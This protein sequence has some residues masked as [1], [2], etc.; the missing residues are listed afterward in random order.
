MDLSS[1]AT[2]CDAAKEK[3]MPPTENSKDRFGQTFRLFNLIENL[4][5]P[6]Q[7][8][9]LRRI[10]GEKLN[11]H[12]FKLIIELTEEQQALLLEQLASATETE[13]PEKTVRLE[14]TEPTMRENIRRTCL[15]NA[16]Y[17][18]RGRSFRSYILDISIGGVFIE[19][20]DRQT[21]GE[22]VTLL[23]SLPDAAQPFKTQGLIAWSGPQGFGVRFENLAPPQGNA[24]R[25]Y[26]EKETSSRTD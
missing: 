15:I 17:T 20:G 24:I 2:P 23:F 16:S 25:T 4:S 7:L 10:I 1:S 19:T 5:R 13:P 3:T 11:E 12:L 21:V 22:P 8:E 9:L 14:G 18:V 6:Q 26:V